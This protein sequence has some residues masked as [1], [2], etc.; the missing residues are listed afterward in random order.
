MGLIAVRRGDA[1]AARQDFEQAMSADSDEVEPLLNLGLLYKRTG[2]NQQAVRYFEMFLAKAPKAQYGT[3]F[4][5]VRE[6]IHEC[7]AQ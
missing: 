2:D 7:R 4:P 6:A 5:E 3:M 1:T